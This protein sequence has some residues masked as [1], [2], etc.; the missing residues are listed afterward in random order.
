M[1][2]ALKTLPPL[3]LA[4]IYATNERQIRRWR[5]DG[6]PLEYP[7][8]MAEWL[9]ARRTRPKATMALLTVKLPATE[10]K[11]RAALTKA[12]LE[13]SSISKPPAAVANPPP[14][15]EPEESLDAEI[16]A[17]R[18]MSHEARAAYHAAKDDPTTPSGRVA[19]LR[20][21]WTEML[22]ELRKME[23]AAPA[24][25]KMNRHAVS[26]AH[27]ESV[28][29]ALFAACRMAL[30]NLPARSAPKLAAV[31]T[32]E[33]IREILKREVEVVSRAWDASATLIFLRAEEVQGRLRAKD[34]GGVAQELNAAGYA[35]AEA[36]DA[37]E[38]REGGR[39]TPHGWQAELERIAHE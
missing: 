10:K 38:Y 5:A 7:S 39:E 11:M 31:R 4:K 30:R 33:E 18:Q 22:G 20:K 14:L 37:R 13:L 35:A 25:R 19:F 12:G 3:R 34:A 16:Q 23:A 27:M 17:L 1:K 36:E 28:L 15:I 32:Q 21:E 26:V 6:A 9:L 2:A 29:S 8:A 24:I